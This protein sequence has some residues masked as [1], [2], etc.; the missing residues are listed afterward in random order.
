MPE[1]NT[2]LK[3]FAALLDWEL[4]LTPVLLAVVLLLCSFYSYLLFHTLAELFAVIVGVVMFVVAMYTYKHARD[5]FVM[6]LATGYFWVAAMDLIHTLLYKGMVI[7]PI[8]LANHSTQFW[9]A[10]RYFE[11]LVLLFA[12]LLCSRWLHNGVRFIAFGLIAV[13]CYVLIMSGYF[14]DAYIEGEGLTRFKII[15]EYIICLILVLAVV[16]L[17]HHQ[18][19]LKPGIFPYLTASIVLTIFA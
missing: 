16:N 15:S 13:V 1:K 18:D 3:Q 5:D 4:W 7:Y 9:I 14:P 6:F 8:D 10:N 2:T 11:S 19:Q 17:Y 12:P